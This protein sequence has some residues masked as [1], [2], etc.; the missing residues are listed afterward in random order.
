MAETLYYIF[1]ISA[2]R[3]LNH[4]KN[5]KHVSPVTDSQTVQIQT[6][7]DTVGH[8]TNSKPCLKS[9]ALLVVC[10]TAL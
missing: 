10:R 7:A 8:E 6:C 1:N 5:S 3:K 2:S 9:T 4:N